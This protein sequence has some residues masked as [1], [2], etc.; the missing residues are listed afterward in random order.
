MMNNK[1]KKTLEEAM[2]YYLQS[3]V[4]SDRKMK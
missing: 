4:L 1:N 2:L 3:Q